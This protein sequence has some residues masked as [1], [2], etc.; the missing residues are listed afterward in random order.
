[1]DDCT[2][3]EEVTLADELM[4]D[5]LAAADED[6]GAAELT[7]AVEEGAGGAALTPEP[8]TVSEKGEAAAEAAAVL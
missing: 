1:M 7:L 5:E 3:E 8:V 6:T 4:E 2:G